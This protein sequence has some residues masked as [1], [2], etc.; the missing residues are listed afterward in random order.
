MFH[1]FRVDPLVVC[2]SKPRPTISSSRRHPSSLNSENK[3]RKVN[4]KCLW[5]IS[6]EMNM[7]VPKPRLSS[8]LDNTHWIENLIAYTNT[9][10]IIVLLGT[11]IAGSFFAFHSPVTIW[12]IRMCNVTNDF[13]VSKK[14]TLYECLFGAL[15]C[16]CLIISTKPYNCSLLL[17][18]AWTSESHA[19]TYSL[20]LSLMSSNCPHIIFVS[21]K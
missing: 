12:L 6:I 15:R 19:N 13:R 14:H 3:K 5:V 17:L 1:F 11:T 9:K 2:R 16:F 21:W 20:Y 7:D 18:H 4:Y 8:P 10:I